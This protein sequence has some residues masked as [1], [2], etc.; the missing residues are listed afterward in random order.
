M[1][2]IWQPRD[3]GIFCAM[4]PTTLRALHH[5]GG[6][7]SLPDL[8]H[9]TALTELRL[10]DTVFTGLPL[11][12]LPAL[13]VLGANGHC[14]S[15]Q[16]TFID[17]GPRDLG[18]A[19]ATPFLTEV[20]FTLGIIVAPHEELAALASL[21]QLKILVLDFG[22]YEGCPPA[23]LLQPTTLLSLPPSVTKLV[24][25]EFNK[26]V[27]ATALPEDIAIVFEGDELP[28]A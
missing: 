22:Y 11:P 18:L 19:T 4:L 24:L 21:A 26:F 2:T 28:E 14:L 9:L 23:N 8:G 20:H 17:P 1:Q 25:M 10:D 15:Q 13:R 3:F 6:R 16:G 7:V 12:H 27:P 5:L